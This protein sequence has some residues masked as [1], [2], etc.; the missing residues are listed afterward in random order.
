VK[1]AVPE[2][3]SAVNVANVQDEPREHIQVTLVPLDISDL[4]DGRLE[5]V[6]VQVYDWRNAIWFERGGDTVCA[7]NQNGAVWCFIR[8]GGSD[9]YIFDAIEVRY[10]VKLYDKGGFDNAVN[11]GAFD[12]PHYEQSSREI[13]AEFISKV[14]ALVKEF[15]PRLGQLWREFGYKKADRQRR[16]EL[17]R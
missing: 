8:V 2:D 15:R 11:M 4:L 3:T 17:Y 10:G 9:D 5:T 7:P 13:R 12:G 16:R 6:G 1:S 14:K